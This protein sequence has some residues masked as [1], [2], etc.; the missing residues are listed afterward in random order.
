MGN[1]L[2][3]K[4]KCLNVDYNNKK[5]NVELLKD[6]SL[7]LSRNH[8]LTEAMLILESR[9]E[10]GVLRE[11][12]LSG[13]SFSQ[14]LQELNY[15]SDIRLIIRINENNGQLLNGINEAI[16]MINIKNSNHKQLM[17]Q[18]RYPLFLIIVIVLVIMF[19]NNFVLPQ[20]LGLYDSFNV[21]LPLVIKIFIMI[22]NALPTV[23]TISLMM[24]VGFMF[25]FNL[26]SF[27]SKLKY[28]SRIPIFGKEYKKMYN[29]LFMNY[30]MN[31]LKS[32]IT[33]AK[34]L[35]ILS[36]QNEHKLL[37]KEALRL[38]KE[39]DEG[40]MFINTLSERLYL[41]S[42]IE[43]FKIGIKQDNLVMCLESHLIKAKE[44]QEVKNQRILFL[45]QPIIYLIIGF[46]IVIVYGLI[47]N[48]CYG[49]IS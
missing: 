20:I 1:Q 42:T 38:K 40:E 4:L 48:I 47:F 46:I 41:K 36:E 21:K 6:F 10:I 11:K 22:L 8:S 28:L 13:N 31:L 19:I 44:N 18:I 37:K 30:I 45:I 17:K 25:S 16:M 15:S 9:Y 27:E 29:I 5:N 12:I 26:L 35:E 14:S 3:K 43:I 23:V 49:L 7:L 2:L 39:L 32:K 34:A 24:L 33:L